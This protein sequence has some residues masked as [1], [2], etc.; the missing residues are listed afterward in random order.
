M[1]KEI[2]TL[3]DYQV[4]CVERGIKILNEYK[5]L[6]IGLKMRLGKSIVCLTIAHRYGAK[7]VLFLT[8]KNAI[9]SIK[10]DHEKSGYN[11]DLT[12]INYEQSENISN[13]FDLI[14][15]DESNEKI[16]SFPKMG[17]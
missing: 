12:V 1:G 14:I 15:L 11:L 2:V 3:F 16:S 7:K 17:K 9:A 8:K 5:L 13:Y 10:S 4:D 6:Y